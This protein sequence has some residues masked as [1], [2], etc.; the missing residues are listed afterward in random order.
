MTGR[1]LVKR[2]LEFGSPERVP[3]RFGGMGETDFCEAW[4]RDTRGR[5]FV[6]TTED[7]W[8]CRW[9]RSLATNMGQVRGHPLAD[10]GAI[11]SYHRPDPLAPKKW[12]E[13]PAQLE[14]ADDKYVL[15]CPGH[16]PFERLHML[17]GF[18]T[19]LADF[20]GNKA[21]NHRVI[22]IV[23]D[24]HIQQLRKAQEISG[25]RIDGCSLADD[26]GTQ[27]GLI[28]GNPV[29]RE[30]YKEQYRALVEECHRLGMHFLLHCCGKINDLIEEFIEIGMDSVNIQQPR[31]LGIEEISRRYRGR[32]CFEPTIDIQSTYSK[33]SY[34][35]IRQEAKMLIEM[36]GTPEGGVIATDYEDN[37]AIGVSNERRKV[38]LE[39][40]KEFGSLDGQRHDSAKVEK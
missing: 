27:S 20:Y 6:D 13:F 40:F 23:I 39:A 30:F 31:T 10:P 16:G 17:R 3:L 11:D 12:E 24:F 29:F 18:D 36:W 28:I 4:P 34:D 15:L 38:A 21:T 26:W 32:I 1:E 2:A 8:G 33:G 19:A 9:E 35:E 7:E 14:G 22:E 37:V 25:G 5:L